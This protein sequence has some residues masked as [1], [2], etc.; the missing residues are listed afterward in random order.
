MFEINK[1]KPLPD[2]RASLITDYPFT[3]MEIGDSFVVPKSLRASALG[4]ARY[5][6]RKHPAYRFV[7]RTIDTDT[8]GVWRVPVSS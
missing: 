6:A 7:S 8:V 4:A 1:G 2:P 5:Y 3:Q